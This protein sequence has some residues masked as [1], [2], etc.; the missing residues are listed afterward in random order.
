MAG[1]SNGYLAFVRVAARGE[2]RLTRKENAGVT[3]MELIVVISILAALT[4]MVLPV[5]HDAYN[6]TRIADGVADFYA[7]LQYAESIAISEAV[8]YRVYVNPEENAYWVAH[9]VGIEQ[10]EK[11]FEEVDDAYR[12]LTYL[13]RKLQF[14]KP[15]AYE[16][17]EIDGAYYIT[18]Y[19][20]GACDYATF[21]IEREGLRFRKYEIETGGRAGRIELRTP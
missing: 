9:L 14:K 18:F 16:D 2:A 10:G 19:P 7:T 11:I 17:P 21:F 3:L 12:R 15:K 1:R 20:S 13:P 8:E 5:Y 4:G 6:S